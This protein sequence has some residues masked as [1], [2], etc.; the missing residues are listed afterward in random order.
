MEFSGVLPVQIMRSEW[1]TKQDKAHVVHMKLL[2][3]RQAPQVLH[4]RR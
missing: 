3:Y 2:R 1:H 4:A